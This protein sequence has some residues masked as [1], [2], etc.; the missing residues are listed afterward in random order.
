[1]Q[2]RIVLMSTLAAVVLSGCVLMPTPAPTGPSFAD[3]SLL[4]IDTAFDIKTIDPG[5]EYEPTGQIIVKALYDTLLTFADN[6]A[7]TILPDLAT[8]TTNA[9]MTEFTFTL[10][11]GRVFSDGT[12]VTADDVVFSLQRLIGL[13][14]NPSFLLNGVTVTKVDDRMVKLTSKSANPALPAILATPSAGILNAEVVQANGGTTDEKDAAEAYLNTNSA[15][16]GPYKLQTLERSTQ[17]V[18]VRNT[19][20]TGPQKPTYD[21][22]VLRNADPATQKADLERGDAQLALDLSG[23]LIASLASDIE[24]ETTPS[25]TVLFLLLN[26]DPTVNQY[27]AK[28]QFVTAVKQAIDYNSLLDL[29]GIGASQA[30]GLVP[31]GFLGALP[32]AQAPKFDLNAAIAN[33]TA[34]DAQGQTIRLSFPEDA[35]PAGIDLSALAQRLQQQLQSAGIT[36]ELAPAPLATETEA[37][38]AGTEQAGLWYWH[39]DYLDPATFLTFSP[40]QPV[41]LRAKWKADADPPIADLVKQAATTSDDTARKALFEQWG[42]AMN[43]RSPFVPLIQPGSNIAHRPSVT[44]VH[45]NPVWLINVAGLGAG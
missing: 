38:R 25:A 15:G 17:A 5:R 23:D 3:E 14:G 1:M 21:K 33:V 31:T 35:R 30:T 16:S 40:G 26:A 10:S 19:A 45:Y 41:G 20:Y 6:D 44:N 4:V 34:A 12:P 11:D 28:P 27:T 24:V 7:T 2:R 18:L 13:K 9:K 8:Y 42:Q 43:A 32:L 37:Y 39:P 22:V 29:A 36:V